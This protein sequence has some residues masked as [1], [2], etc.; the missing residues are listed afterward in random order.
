LGGGAAVCRGEAQVGLDRRLVRV[1][2]AGEPGDLTRPGLGV[3][4]L[5]IAGL[6][7]LERGVDE[8]LDERQAHRLVD[9]AR[10]VAIG[11][12]G[13][14]DRHE[15]HHARV[16]EQAGDLADAADVLGAVGGREPEVGVEAVAHVVAVEQVGGTAGGHERALD[17]DRHGRLARPR[18]AREP[19]GRTGALAVG[20]SHGPVVPDDV[21]RRRH[22]RITPPRWAR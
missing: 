17:L 19:D 12:V 16:G 2:D 10:P 9:G 13:A 22:A 14:D 1:V 4:P 18:Q 20:P 5:G 21:V 15:R 8:H 7:H 6:A 3:Q 11:P